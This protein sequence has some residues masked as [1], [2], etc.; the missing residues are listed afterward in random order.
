MPSVTASGV[1]VTVPLLKTVRQL[2][3]RNIGAKLIASVAAHARSPA[4]T[5]HGRVTAPPVE[6][7]AAVGAAALPLLVPAES[8]FSLTMPF[9]AFARLF[10]SLSELAA[11]SPVSAAAAALNNTS[12]AAAALGSSAYGVNGGVNG[13]PAGQVTVGV[14]LSPSLAAEFVAH[15][16]PSSM[17][18]A[19]GSSTLLSVLHYVFA[20]CASADAA[21]AAGGNTVSQSHSNAALAPSV[22]NGASVNNGG[23]HGGSNSPVAVEPV[24]TYSLFGDALLALAAYAVRDPFLTPAEKLARFLDKHMLAGYCVA[25]AVAA[26]LAAA[27]ASA[28]SVVRGESR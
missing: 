6:L 12:N 18:I 17:S 28:N 8:L 7:A 16:L 10:Q 26:A 24:L 22:E 5:A 2:L 3:D 1:S 19:A 27:S 13:G 14:A 25:P 20:A 21:A 4:G 9:K 11:P 15:S 23:G